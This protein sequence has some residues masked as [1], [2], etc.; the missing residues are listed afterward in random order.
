MNDAATRTDTTPLLRTLSPALR[1]GIAIRFA[2]EVAMLLFIDESGHDNSGT[3]CEV[4]AGVAVTEDNLW[5]LV[6]AI[7]APEREHFG[8][9]LRVFTVEERKA[10]KLLKTKRFKSA[11]RKV[12]IAEAEW[13]R[14]ARDYV[15]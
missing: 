4:L 11:N 7:R 5:N 14:T 2:Q 9:Y 12:H 10:K 15:Y 6:R 1:G 13:T 3:P 8:D